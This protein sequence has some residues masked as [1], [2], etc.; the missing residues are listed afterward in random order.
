[1]IFRNEK[2]QVSLLGIVIASVGTVIASVLGGWSAA[3]ST[4]SIKVQVVEEREK[5][6]YEELG[7][8][9]DKV[10]KAFED[11]NRKMDS[12]IMKDKK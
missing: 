6:H 11:I 5:N 8:R 2:G 9:F 12:F 7:K 4:A 1:M 3:S 10:D